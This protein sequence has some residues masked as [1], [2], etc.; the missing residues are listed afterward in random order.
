MVSI[1]LC[2][3]RE[4]SSILGIVVEGCGEYSYFVFVWKLLYS[5]ILPLTCIRSSTGTSYTACRS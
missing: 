3:S 1:L 5:I 4:S 2:H